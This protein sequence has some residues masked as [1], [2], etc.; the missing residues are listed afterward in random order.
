MAFDLRKTKPNTAYPLARVEV[1]VDEKHYWL[2][3]AAVN[4][5]P[6]SVLLGRDVPELVKIGPTV[7]GPKKSLVMAATTRA[8]AKKRME[9]DARTVQKEKQSGAKATPVMEQ[10][11]SDVA[12]DSLK[13]SLDNAAVL[14]KAEGLK[15][16]EKP[17][18]LDGEGEKLFNVE[19]IQRLQRE[20]PTLQPLWKAAKGERTKVNVWFYEENGMLYRHWQPLSDG[21]GLA[22]EQLVL[23]VAVRRTVM[24]VAHEI[25]L[26]GHMGKKRTVQRV[27]QRFYWP[28]VYRDVAEWCRC[29]AI[30]QK[31][32]RGRKGYASLMPVALKSINADALSRAFSDGATGVSLEKGGGVSWSK[33][34]HDESEEGDPMNRCQGAECKEG[35]WMKGGPTLK[36]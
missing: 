11:D 14:H 17:E 16:P 15:A 29:C 8:Q 24:T 34:K 10:V 19:K 23:P 32:S 35:R 9:E 3:A 18:H 4:K 25:P 6:M 20:D 13:N 36:G 7:E 1:I 27:L 26:A 2:E 31:C 21:E 22:I 28:S 12:M 30:C 33:A 5:L